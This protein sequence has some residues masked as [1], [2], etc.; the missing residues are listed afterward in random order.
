MRKKLAITAAEIRNTILR[1]C[2]TLLPQVGVGLITLSIF[3]A[4]KCQL[5]ST[6]AGV[7]AR[8][9]TALRLTVLYLW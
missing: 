7:K 1:K 6:L 5:L 8:P 4:A 9:I 2:G 3:I